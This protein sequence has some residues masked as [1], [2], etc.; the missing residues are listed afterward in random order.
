MPFY[1]YK[2]KNL[3]GEEEEGTL[4]ASD[5]SRLARLLRSRGYFLVSLSGEGIDTAKEEKKFGLDFLKKLF[6][7]S[8]KEKLFFTKNLSLMIKTGVPL[9]RAFEILINQIKNEEFKQALRQVSQKV[10]KGESLSQS[11]FCFPKIFPKIYQETLKIGEETGKIEDSLEILARQMERE[12]GLKAQ[13]AAAMVYPLVVVIT[14]IGIGLVMFTF[15]VPKLKVV[16]TDLK[17]KLP[18]TTRIMLSFS[19][20]LSKNWF[21]S[22]LIIFCLISG[23]LFLWKKQSGGK[24]L[25]KLFLIIPVISN[26]VRD[27]NSALV[28]RILSSLFSAG[29]PIVHSLEI[30]SESLSN[31]YFRQSLKETAQKIKKGQKFS[32]ALIPYERLYSPS[33]LEMI[34]VGEETGE[35]VKILEELAL[36]YEKEINTALQ[37]ISSIIEPFLI[38]IIGIF[39]GFFAVS[40]LQPMFSLIQTF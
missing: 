23:L 36:F 7:V 17:I 29:V 37:K 2:A 33:V 34:K 40:M 39:V 14:V 1:F 13:I 3:Q 4:E 8:L 11:L 18:V 5:P 35:T 21:L 6:P 30:A 25:S 31:F 20:F 16:F 10:I 32:Q 28:L 38:I 27:F 9:S 15:V 24:I 19:D 22:G 26:L 12:Y